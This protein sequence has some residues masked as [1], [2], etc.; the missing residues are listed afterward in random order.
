[1]SPK[2]TWDGFPKSHFT[3]TNGSIAKH[4][5]FDETAIHDDFVSFP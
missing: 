1:M 4:P 2:N 3:E 5:I